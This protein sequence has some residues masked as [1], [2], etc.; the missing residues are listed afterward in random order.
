MSRYAAIHQPNFFPWLGY[1]N[2]IALADIFVLLDDAQH[3]KTGA[4]WSNRTRL[5]FA[6]GVRWLTAPI[7]RPDH[8]TEHVNQVKWADQPWREKI[9]GSLETHYR[10]A[11]HYRSAMALLRPLVENPEPALAAYNLHAIKAI[12]SALGLQTEFVLAS[13]FG[14]CSSSTQRLIDLTRATGCGGYLAGGGSAG[15]QDDALFA[16]AGLTL[17]FQSFVHPDYPQAGAREFTPGL[18]VMD[19]LMHC[20]IARTSQLIVS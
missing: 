3:T 8:G 12:A 6:G 17:K 20:G 5:L 7:Q 18:S 14:L 9:V 19:A 2:K 4:N 11:A 13:Q 10:R 16:Q 1:F 15:Y